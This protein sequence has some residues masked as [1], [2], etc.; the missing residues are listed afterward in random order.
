MSLK[1]NRCVAIIGC[2]SHARLRY[3]NQNPFLLHCNNGQTTAPRLSVAPLAQEVSNAVRIMVW[4]RGYLWLCVIMLIIQ[5]SCGCMLNYYWEKN[6]F[7]LDRVANTIFV[8][9]GVPLYILPELRTICSACTEVFL[10]HELCKRL[11][12][13]DGSNS[14]VFNSRT[15][16]API[17]VTPSSWCKKLHQKL[18][19][20]NV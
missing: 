12:L 3:A 2:G 15:P 11:R 10:T 16:N 6:V 18:V 7:L 13:V 17:S 8:L 9:Q 5:V 20:P 19:I 1:K 4:R 14:S